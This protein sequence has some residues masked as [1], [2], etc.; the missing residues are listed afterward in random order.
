MVAVDNQN[1]MSNFIQLNVYKTAKQMDV[2]EAK[3]A[4]LFQA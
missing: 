3:C 4:K 1:F 2:G